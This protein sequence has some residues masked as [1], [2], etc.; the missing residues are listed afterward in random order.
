MALP[1]KFTEVVQVRSHAYLHMES[2]ADYLTQLTN[3]DIAVS[4][5]SSRPATQTQLAAC[6][7]LGQRTA[8]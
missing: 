5:F 7:G 2:P 1:I 4:V 8:Y 3:L 6:A